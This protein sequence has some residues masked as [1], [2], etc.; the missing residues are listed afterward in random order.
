MFSR[1]FG[2][3]NKK[4]NSVKYIKPKLEFLEERLT[5]SDTYT[6]NPQPGGNNL[7]NIAN[8]WYDE[9]TQAQA[10]TVPSTTT[11]VY[12]KGA[13]SNQICYVNT[14]TFCNSVFVDSSFTQVLDLSG[15]SINVTGAGT[16]N[17][18]T[19][20]S[21]SSN[22]DTI[23]CST[24]D[25]ALNVQGGTFD[26]EG[27]SLNLTGSS[28]EIPRNLYV[29]ATGGSHFLVNS[30]CK[31][32]GANL[33]AGGVTSGTIDFGTVTQNFGYRFTNEGVATATAKGTIS[34]DDYAQE[35]N[36]SISISNGGKFVMGNN[37]NIVMGVGDI[38]VLD[39]SIFSTNN[40]AAKSIGYIEGQL[41]LVHSSELDLASFD[42]NY[43]ELDVTNLVL[44]T[45]TYI[46]DVNGQ[47]GG[48]GNDTCDKVS[49][50]STILLGGDTSSCYTKG[51]PTPGKHDY[52]P[53]ST[54]PGGIRG[55]FNKCIWNGDGGP[56][57]WAYG[58]NN[59][60]DFPFGFHL[61]ESAART[62][63]WTGADPLYPKRWEIAD[64]WFD[65]STQ[66][67][68]TSAPDQFTECFFQNDSPT[69][70]NLHFQNDCETITT[71]PGWNGVIKLRRALLNVHGNNASGDISDI[72][73]GSISI[74]R[75]GRLNQIGGTFEY[76]ASSLGNNFATNLDGVLKV[77]VGSGG[78]FTVDTNCTSINATFF[79][80]Q[81]SP[82]SPASVTI[83]GPGTLTFN[84]IGSSTCAMSNNSYIVVGVQGT[85]GFNNHSSLVGLGLF[86]YG[87]VHIGNSNVGFPYPDVTLT[88][89]VSNPTIFV[90]S[91][92]LLDTVDVG[93]D[94]INGNV[95]IMSGGTLR[96]G[97]D[98]DAGF[99]GSLNING[100]L[101]F[102]T[103]STYDVAVNLNYLSWA[104]V[105]ATGGTINPGVT[106]HVRADGEPQPTGWFYTFPILNGVSGAGFDTITQ[107]GPVENWTFNSTT[108][109][110]EA[111]Q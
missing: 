78:T 33:Q 81:D 43:Y 35:T 10:F 108:D 63:L 7:W 14:T 57:K 101:T 83:T 71:S 82:G 6:W 80:G 84:T 94:I 76:N 97:A 87:V 16:L 107:E 3:K 58:Y 20:L 66:S 11:N 15:G 27:Y 12:F 102:D 30:N 54:G 86:D 25:G 62:L 24:K 111:T 29:N 60:G 64:N 1:F 55:N 52:Y 96:K 85:L 49:T 70:C 28:T 32:M 38:F 19:V 90:E 46:Y 8:N 73:G 75:G 99:Y 42:G 47:S 50:V 77:T 95:E 5:P 104:N 93:T 88:T 98:S 100:T 26:Y 74:V 92:G 22:S 34:F 72:E 103:G 13:T 18:S 79:V 67:L 106:L 51:V 65:V 53:I 91:G 31:L 17:I 41:K 4:K 56:F 59:F 89:S 68:A 39:D 36:A 40:S 9:G 48:T 109:R 2:K 110:L 44:E 21:N 37:S 23:Q 45:T 69:I 105:S 61:A